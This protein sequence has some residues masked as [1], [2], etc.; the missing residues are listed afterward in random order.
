[1]R[2]QANLLRIMLPRS[3]PNRAVSVF[4]A[5][6]GSGKSC[7][8]DQNTVIPRSSLCRRGHEGQVTEVHPPG[9]QKR[10]ARRHKSGPLPTGL[11]S[12]LREATAFIPPNWSAQIAAFGAE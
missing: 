12:R 6:F 10:V 9:A 7:P 5:S 2:G 3:R 4:S 1:M 11:L 8:D